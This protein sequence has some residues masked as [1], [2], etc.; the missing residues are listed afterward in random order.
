MI[1]PFKR[2]EPVVVEPD[3]EKNM[4]QQ[5]EIQEKLNFPAGNSAKWLHMHKILLDYE[6]RLRA[7][8]EK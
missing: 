8:E 5:I 7:L 3:Y 4:Q 1:W 6:M 2:K